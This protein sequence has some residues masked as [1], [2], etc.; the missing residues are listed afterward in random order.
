MNSDEHVLKTESQG[1]LEAG[2]H[3]PTTDIGWLQSLRIPGP[4]AVADCKVIGRFASGPTA[5]PP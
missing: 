4:L 5:V 3:L 1:E 2:A